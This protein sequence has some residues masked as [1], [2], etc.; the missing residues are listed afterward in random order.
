MV[1]LDEAG[2]AASA[3][4]ACSS[5]A[6]EAS[7]VLAS[8]GL[9]GRGGSGVRFSLGVTTTDEDVD[10]P[11]PCPAG[12]VEPPAELS[13]CAS[14]CHVRWCRLVGGRRPAGRRLG[15]DEVVG[16]TLKLWGGDFQLAL[17]LGR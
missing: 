5:G 4:A 2:V 8:M 9:T 7:H 11:R 17:L 10:G 1:L 14:W 12:V 3:G 16:A 15:T 13:R 6:V